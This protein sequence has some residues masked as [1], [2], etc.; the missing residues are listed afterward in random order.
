MSSVLQKALN[1]R[2]QDVEAAALKA[3][4]QVSEVEKLI[5]E[6]GFSITSGAPVLKAGPYVFLKA[7]DGLFDFNEDLRMVIHAAHFPSDKYCNNLA[8]SALGHVGWSCIS[9]EPGNYRLTDGEMV[10]EFDLTFGIQLWPLELYQDIYAKWEKDLC[11]MDLAHV[12]LSKDVKPKA[13]R[14]SAAIGNIMIK[15]GGSGG[16]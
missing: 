6:L 7:S 3:S 8:I 9:I 15:R 13:H 12:E 14:C 1:K 10:H 16:L 11:I 2:K 4:A 5:E